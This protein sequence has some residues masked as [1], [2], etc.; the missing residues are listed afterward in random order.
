MAS[1]VFQSYSQILTTG[2]VRL[3]KSYRTEY[4]DGKQ[5]RD[6]IYVKDVVKV[7]QFFM[8][9]GEKNGIVNVGTGE[10]R[11]FLD[12]A[13]CV[14]HTLDKEPA[15]DFVEMPEGLKHQYQYSTRASVDKLRAFG[16]PEP[17]SSLEAGVRDY[18]T[19]Y[20]ARVREGL[21]G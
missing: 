17:F 14:Y 9:H 6:F 18:I 5:L 1:F 2:R 11:T 19:G 15:I 8:E 4:A 3:F 20:L 10:A 12:V 7:V 16:Y 13:R 21:P